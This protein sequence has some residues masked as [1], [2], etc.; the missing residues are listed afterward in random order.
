MFLIPEIEFIN[1]SAGDFFMI[2]LINGAADIIDSELYSNLSNNNF[3]QI[4]KSI[5]RNMKS[6]K[7]LFD[8]EDDYKEFISDINNKISCAEQEA[9]PNFL[10]IPSYSCN[11][12]CIYCY[13]QTYKMSN[14]NNMDPLSV[15]DIEF[16]RIDEIVEAHRK[17]TNNNSQDIRI[18]IMG[19]EPL[20]S[21]NKKII[22]TIFQKCHERRY[23][24]DIVTN[25][26][27][28]NIYI[29]LFKKYNDILDHI[30]I[31]LDGAKDI[32]DKR[33]IFANGKGSFDLIIDNIALALENNILTYLRA[34]IDSSNIKQLGQLADILVTKFEKHLD[35]LKPYIYIL[36]DGG[37]SGENNIISEDVSIK[38]IFELEDINPNISIFYKKY[39][40]AEFIN[41]IFSNT[42]YQPV[43]RHC[44]A[45]KKQYIF[46]CNLNMYKCF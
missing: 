42:P 40:P 45:S 35:K 19:G 38:E 41:S 37:C 8:N 20:L 9:P 13:E 12:K 29:E 32:H 44:G 23:T 18:T 26:V 36:Q 28:L 10:I 4:S 11:L 22:E 33:R 34:N 30:Q 15:L 24:V 46:D 21:C 39:H 3:S 2:N 16:Q 43:L 1:I 6:R 7:Y 31:T 25:G 5:I 14:K 27:E 17:E